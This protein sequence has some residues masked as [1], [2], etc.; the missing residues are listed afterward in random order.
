M[1]D[2]RGSKDELNPQIRGSSAS[3]PVSSIPP[4]ARKST[5]ILNSTHQQRDSIG[6]LYPRTNYTMDQ[7]RYYERS[8]SDS[9]NPQQRTQQPPFSPVGA[10]LGAGASSDAATVA[11]RPTRTRVSRWA[12]LPADRDEP[13]AFSNTANNESADAGNYHRFNSGG[14]P[15]ASNITNLYNTQPPIQQQQSQLGDYRRASPPPPRM[16][17]SA[18]IASGSSYTSPRNAMA[19]HNN[20]NRSPP[21]RYHNE[22]RFQND[23]DNRSLP[24]NQY[25]RSP[26][27]DFSPSESR[28]SLMSQMGKRSR[29]ED[30]IPIPS[31][32]PSMMQGVGIKQQPISRDDEEAEEE[33]LNVAD[34]D[35]AAPEEE[36]ED[37]GGID[38]EDIEQKI[39]SLDAEIA[40]YEALLQEMRQK[41]EAGSFNADGNSNQS[42]DASIEE[43]A[44]G[45]ATPAMQEP[46]DILQLAE[47]ENEPFVVAPGLPL[48]E[49]IYM[50]NRH[51]ARVT[52]R[53]M[54]LQ[55]RSLS[56]PSQPLPSQQIY[57]IEDFDFYT[58]N[59]ESHRTFRPLLVQHIQN[60]RRDM[61]DKRDELRQ[62]YQEL[63]DVWKK[64]I[65]RLDR[66]KER[67]RKKTGPA[68]TSIPER[69]ALYHNSMSNS[70]AA[71]L[72]MYGGG[73]LTRRSRAAANASFNSD[74][75]RSEAEFTAAIA[76][77]MTLDG[78]IDPSR[79]APIPDMILEPIER[80]SVV[81]S[82]LSQLVRDPIDE[83]R[84]LLESASQCWSDEDKY[85]FEVKLVQIGKNF[86]KIAEFLP[87]KTTQDCVRH[88]YREKER[89][90]FKT[91]LRRTA[92]G[93]G[94]GGLRRARGGALARK[95]LQTGFG[96]SSTTSIDPNGVVEEV[97]LE[98]YDED[99]AMDIER[100]RR[101]TRDAPANRKQKVKP[102]VIQP[103]SDGDDHAIDV[104]GGG[105]P[106]GPGNNTTTGS[107]SISN[108]KWTDDDKSKMI[109]ALQQFGRDWNGVSSFMGNKT[110]NE[111]KIYY[112]QN[113]FR[114]GLD[115][116]LRV[117]DTSRRSM[118]RKKRAGGPSYNNDDNA[119]EDGGVSL[120]ED[121][122]GNEDSRGEDG[123]DMDDPDILEEA[124]P[125]KKKNARKP[126]QTGITM[127]NNSSIDVMG[128]EP[129]SEDARSRVRGGRTRKS[130]G[131]ARKSRP[132]VIEEIPDL[133]SVMDAS[134]SYDPNDSIGASRKTVSYWSVR[135]R[136]AFV[137]AI[138]KVGC[139]WEAI[140][141]MV[142]TKSSVQVRNYYSSHAKELGV[143][144][145]TNLILQPHNVNR[146]K[147]YEEQQQ[148]QQR[149]STPPTQPHREDGGAGEEYVHSGHRRT[150]SQSSTGSHSRRRDE[151]TYI[152]A[153]DLLTMARGSNSPHLYAVGA[154][155]QGGQ[156]QPIYAQS[157]RGILPPMVSLPPGSVANTI[158][159]QHAQ[160]PPG[161]TTFALPPVYIPYDRAA[162]AA[163]IQHLAVPYAAGPGGAF[164]YP[165][166]F[167]FSA[168]GPDYQAHPIAIQQM[169]PE[170]DV[171]QA[172]RHS[173]PV[174]RESPQRRGGSVPLHGPP[175][176]A[177]SNMAPPSLLIRHDEGMRTV[178]PS[179]RSLISAAEGAEGLGIQMPP[180]HQ[181]APIGQY[182]AIPPPMHTNLP[183]FAP[184]NSRGRSRSASPGY[185][186]FGSS[187][188]QLPQQQQHH[189][190]H[191]HHQ[192]HQQ[193]QHHQQHVQHH[194]QQYRATSPGTMMVPSGIG[195]ASAASV[196][197]AIDDLRKHENQMPRMDAP[198]V[199]VTAMS[200]VLDGRR[201]VAE[202]R[203]IDVPR[204]DVQG[205]EANNQMDEG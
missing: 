138:Q 188:Q 108:V 115:E 109:E 111:C 196:G 46:P 18:P 57:K 145:I 200:E 44:P 79:L 155:Q 132:N 167:Y 158:M 112:R 110:E 9:N 78:N 198:V 37:D 202:S 52:A 203:A 80:N 159:T 24:S 56:D 64:Q 69:P 133:S 113:R 3:I 142:G 59:I 45:T 28:P 1:S 49:E 170:M 174:R 6:D 15:T 88:Y 156:Y 87:G 50:A 51:R 72:M 140:A 154:G 23:A 53:A 134:E 86:R 177:G 8:N 169:R 127:N 74:L 137:S 19:T 101:N 102:P 128:N 26:Q 107:S 2:A 147:S 55:A 83:N 35:E 114:L 71:D 14:A 81:H 39:D 29:T 97:D 197:S 62:T 120:G 163:T 104:S 129:A 90:G 160:F 146:A 204:N 16:R 89:L 192:P 176:P 130:T 105:G 149:L 30:M 31:N 131:A 168:G 12:P 70:G 183:A 122:G 201:E 82:D 161:T 22:F 126:T 136:E 135:E 173:S 119:D 42:K 124:R 95:L 121:Q 38:N 191:Q 190:H 157:A 144:H 27:N 67:K 93:P 193:H 180:T 166:D 77:I 179:V 205:S 186:A 150:P 106:P 76:H 5:S 66:E 84:R 4:S 148:Q 178:L 13:A 195:M 92:P 194:Q 94:R 75:V 34:D 48:H 10:S 185:A 33:D 91:L 7:Q 189:Q 152:A 164:Q 141:K 165:R 40:K 63:H 32:R 125:K 96:G 36:D 17:I 85:V 139:D 20:T 41:K 54:A 182:H 47:I 117:N 184:D 118:P 153:A 60:R 68:P 123:E 99:V 65:E 58:A 73:T 199:V 103:D 143:D 116:I 43:G 151:A 181:L 11:P 172:E 187:Q 175:S 100:L 98:E 25:N 162:A 171:D 21:H 61:M